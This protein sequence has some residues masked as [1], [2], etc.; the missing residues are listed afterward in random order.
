MKRLSIAGPIFCGSE[1]ER[2]KARKEWQELMEDTMRRI[3]ND[4]TA[5]SLDTSQT[6]GNITLDV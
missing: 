2:D 5:V 6:S 3:A 4:V 1:E